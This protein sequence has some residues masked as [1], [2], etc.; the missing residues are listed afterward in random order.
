M[1]IDTEKYKL[2]KEMY[3]N[4]KSLTQIQKEIGFERHKLS[5]LLQQEGISIK[6]NGQKHEYNT[7]FF[8][9]ID[10]EEKAYWLGFLYADGNVINYG[11]YEVKLSLAY[12][13]LSHIEKFANVMIKNGNGKDLVYSYQ[14]KFKEKEYPSAKVV[15][16]NKKIVE[17]LIDLGCKPN[18]SLSLT[19]PTEQQVPKELVRHFIRGYFDGDGSISTPRYAQNIKKKCAGQLRNNGRTISFLGTYSFL[20]S[21]INIFRNVCTNFGVVTLSKKK[22]NQAWQ[23]SKTKYDVNKEI[24]E[25]LYKDA[26]IYL[27]R[28]YK[29]FASLYGKL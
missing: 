29:R 6:M 17:Q 10:T 20:M 26:T 24:Y 16:A 13:D 28:K 9:V 2:A 15:I 25:Y 23:F 18:K 27:E 7:D 22:N 5:Y 4:G 1:I 11:K 3:L 21:I 8:K 12:K 14:A 19:F